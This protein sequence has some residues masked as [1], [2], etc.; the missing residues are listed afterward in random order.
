M[1]RKIKVLTDSEGLDRRE[2]GYYS[3]PSFIAEYLTDEMLRI[4]PHG[5]KV[6]D[7]ATGNEEL[8]SFFHEAGKKIDSYDIINHGNYKYSNFHCED[9]LEFYISRLQCFPMECE[10]YDYII[11]NPPYNCHEVS[12]IKD[13]KQ[14]L[15][16]AFPV[17]AYN[18]YSMFL[19]A[20]IS[21]AKDGC[22]IG[23]IISDSFLTATLH[24]K[25]REQ[26]FTECSIHQLLLCPNDLF[27]SQNADVRTCLLLLQKG[28]SYQKE[29]S[30]MNR[31]R[32]TEEFKYN[33]NHRLFKV[34]ELDSIRL[35]R[36]KELNQFIIDINDD[37]LDIFKNN[38]ALGAKYSCVTCISTGNDKKYLSKEPKP[39]FTVPFYKNPAKRKFITSPDAYLIDNYM[40]ESLKVKDFMVRNK[41]LINE[42]GIACS[43]MGLPFS[44]AYKPK[45]AVTGV[46]ATIFPGKENIYWLISYLNS[47]LVTFFVRGVLIRS[48]MVTSGYVSRIPLLNLSDVVK[49]EL[50][51]I[52][53]MVLTGDIQEREA[54]SMIDNIVFEQSCL[55]DASMKK[56]S[57]FVKH[58]GK[59][60]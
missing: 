3:T 23:V 17:G 56:I 28:R 39:G 46:N 16:A 15:N 54:L 26:I 20:M 18:M 55:S 42:E 53:K 51:I 58:L 25:L 19:S 48:N 59:T 49:K 43:S 32:N 5:N 13:N 9:F 47:S 40:E 29:I 37:I 12:Y 24:A 14:R 60:V 21:I 44:A 45:N 57:V 4:N 35:G 52:S 34:T 38:T 11:A 33:L 8:L 2:V 36:K 27:W 50:S 30:I 10:E 41:A 6:L 31:P 7:P 1:A 22:L